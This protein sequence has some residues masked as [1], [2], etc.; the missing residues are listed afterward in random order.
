MKKLTLRFGDLL[1][2]ETM[3][4]IF[5][6]YYLEFSNSK[7]FWRM[8][9]TREAIGSVSL[10]LSEREIGANCF[11]FFFLWWLMPRQQLK[12]VRQRWLFLS[13]C[14]GL[15]GQMSPISVFE[16]DIYFA[17][18]GILCVLDYGKTSIALLLKGGK[19]GFEILSI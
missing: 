13:L 19:T 4:S 10:C 8:L 9:N 14:V 15:K 18:V 1:L 2:R 6:F 7:S 3:P 16:T 12:S 11:F 5:Q 17:G